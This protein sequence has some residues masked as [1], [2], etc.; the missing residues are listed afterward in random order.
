MPR[1]RGTLFLNSIDFV[2]ETFGPTAHARVVSAL[3]A[4]RRGPFLGSLREASWKPV[5]DLI[6]YMETAHRLL[7]PDDGDCYRKMG[8]FAGRRDRETRAFGV[9]LADPKISAKMGPTLWRAFFDKGRIQIADR[10]PVGATVKILGFPTHRVLCQRIAGS[11]EGQQG[12]FAAIAEEKACVLDGAP[13]C[14]FRVTWR[15]AP[16]G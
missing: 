3:P 11:L 10:G 4:E 15:A 14:E 12:Q 9:M 13:H 5:A 8:R 7:A 1:A 16:G 2:R 6:A